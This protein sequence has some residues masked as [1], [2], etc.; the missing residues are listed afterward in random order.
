MEIGA[1][2]LDTTLNLPTLVTLIIAIVAFIAWLVRMEGR[3]GTHDTT[4][5]QLQ[6]TQSA[7]EA[8]VLLHKEQF[9]EYQLQAA[10]DYVTHTVI[11]EIKREIITELAHL[12]TRV[13]RQIDRLV[14]EKE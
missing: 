2:T 11:G 1:L 14:K 5:E 3:V 13:E 4:I 6:K 8:L 12:E 9:R 7:L 10:K